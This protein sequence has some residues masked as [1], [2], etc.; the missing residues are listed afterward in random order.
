MIRNDSFIDRPMNFLFNSTDYIAT[1]C[2]KVISDFSDRDVVRHH[3]LS[4]KL[5]IFCLCNDFTTT[6]MLHQITSLNLFLQG[7]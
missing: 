2:S 3:V 1:Y 4:M 6:N 7:S 5:H